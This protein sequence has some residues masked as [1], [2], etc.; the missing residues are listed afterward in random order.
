MLCGRWATAGGC[1]LQRPMLLLVAALV[2]L[3]VLAVAFVLLRELLDD[4]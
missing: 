1:N 3:V 2:I 4:G